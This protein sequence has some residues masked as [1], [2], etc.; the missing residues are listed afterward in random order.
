MGL[1]NSE[2]NLKM[3][4]AVKILDESYGEN[5]QPIEDLGGILV[6]IEEEEDWNSVSELFHL[7]MGYEEYIEI[8]YKDKK[9]TILEILFQISSDYSVLIYTNQKYIKEL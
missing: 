3:R 9:E 1:I 4:Q 7:Q 8:C 2:I 6:L 5:R